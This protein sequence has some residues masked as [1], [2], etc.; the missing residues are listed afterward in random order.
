MTSTI[1]SGT[2]HEQLFSKLPWLANNT[3]SAAERDQ[4]MQHLSQCQRCEDEYN[5]LTM[6]NTVINSVSADTPDTNASFARMKHRIALEKEQ[7]TV[8]NALLRSVRKFSQ[9]FTPVTTPQWAFAAICGITAMLFMLQYDS[10]TQPESENPYRVLSAADQSETI[11]VFVQL[12]SDVSASQTEKLMTEISNQSDFGLTH[13]NTD[14][15][16]FNIVIKQSDSEP[17]ASPAALASFIEDVRVLDGVADV[18]LS[19]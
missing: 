10:R 8:D 7:S 1:P 9:L 13:I 3:L 14:G 15:D 12:N 4:L 11:E 17:L 6:M 5:S 16:G 2:E 19:P 18:R